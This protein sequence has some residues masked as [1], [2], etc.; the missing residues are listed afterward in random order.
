MMKSN[1]QCDAALA[2][3]LTRAAS[4]QT[5]L[6][7]RCLVDKGM[8]EDA[9]RT[10]GYFRWVDDW[11]D[12]EARPRHERLAFIAR[13]KDLMDR[14]YHGEP[15][16]NLTP[17]EYMLAN[18]IA[19]D[20]EPN[21]GLQAYIR[22]MMT[23]MAFDSERRERLIS[24]LELDNYTAWLAK[25]VTEAMHYFIGHGCASPKCAARYQ[26]VSGAHITHML[27]DAVEDADTGYYNIPSE[28]VAAHRIKPWDVNAPAYR[29]W[30]EERVREARQCFKAGR[31]Y[32]I[33]VESLHCR[34]AGYAY[35]HRFEMALGSIE[36]DGYLLRR[37]Y[38]ELTEAGR[39]MEMIGLALWK[40]IKYRRM[41]SLS[42]ALPVR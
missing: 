22:N 21:S 5:D 39:T 34:L 32:L 29:E 31:G 35:M 11:L 12:Q 13:Q 33:Q 25:A 36:R 24:A 7:I 26:A 17:E 42:P 23:V 41:P 38:P 20:R 40:A 28:F 4:R 1:L 8:V 27:R 6:T 3:A 18:L 10:Y 9:Y 19:R 16:R 2:A 37:H 15:T 30:V 14:C